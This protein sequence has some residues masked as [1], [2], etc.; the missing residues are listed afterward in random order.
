MTLS[1]AYCL[2]VK[3]IYYEMITAVSLFNI[4]HHTQQKCVCDE[5]HI[6]K[7]FPN[8]FTS[9]CSFLTADLLIF[10]IDNTISDR[11]GKTVLKSVLLSESSQ[12][13]SRVI[14]FCHLPIFLFFI[15][16]LKWPMVL[17]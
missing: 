13:F 4:R 15:P 5:W 9:T 10:D 11:S 14:F 3:S 16:V 12:V 6:L 8:V 1:G 2:L 17:V 7:H